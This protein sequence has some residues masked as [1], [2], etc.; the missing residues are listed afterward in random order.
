ML[1]L[2]LVYLYGSCIWEQSF[3]GKKLLMRDSFQMSYRVIYQH[4]LF[5]GAS[6][7]LGKLKSFILPIR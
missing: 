4:S 1:L 2:L 7:C 5:N 3:R 6:Y